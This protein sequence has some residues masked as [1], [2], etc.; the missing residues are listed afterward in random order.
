MTISSVL[1][2]PHSTYGESEIVRCIWGGDYSTIESTIGETYAFSTCGAAW[3]IELTL[4][5]FKGGS[6]LIFN[7]EELSSRD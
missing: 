6:V 1:T 3:D 5:N 7:A 2:S 4:S